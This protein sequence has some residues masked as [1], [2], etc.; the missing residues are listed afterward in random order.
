MK[1]IFL[2]VLVILTL[3]GCGGKAQDKVISEP[4]RESTEKVAVAPADKKNPCRLL[5]ANR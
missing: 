3:S 4:E 2:L 1:R 5:F